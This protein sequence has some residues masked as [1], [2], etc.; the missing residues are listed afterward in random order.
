MRSMPLSFLLVILGLLISPAQSKPLDEFWI[1]TEARKANTTM[2]T[3]EIVAGKS[4]GPIRLR[5]N[6]EEIAHALSSLNQEFPPTLE[7]LGM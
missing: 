5:I 2:I 7:D 6:H 4:I 3:L 1:F